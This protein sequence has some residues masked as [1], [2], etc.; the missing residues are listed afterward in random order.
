MELILLTLCIKSLCDTVKNGLEKWDD[1]PCYTVPCDHWADGCYSVDK[2]SIE[3]QIAKDSNLNPF[4]A[5]CLF[6]RTQATSIDL[7]PSNENA[8]TEM[9]F[10]NA[11]A[12][13]LDKDASF[14]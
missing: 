6:L 13:I 14:L 5:Y 3:N 9:C 12:N 11:F 1:L 4:A 10:S 2:S 8:E 7:I